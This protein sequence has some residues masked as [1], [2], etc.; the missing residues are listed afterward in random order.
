[1]FTLWPQENNQKGNVMEEGGVD[2]V[3][4]E[5]GEM[6]NDLGLLCEQIRRGLR[7]VTALRRAIKFATMPQNPI[8]VG[9]RD[10]GSVEEARR[11]VAERLELLSAISVEVNFPAGLET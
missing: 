10:G 3:M 7:R 1:M 9:S 11:L 2:V 5:A 6:A 4:K 8:P